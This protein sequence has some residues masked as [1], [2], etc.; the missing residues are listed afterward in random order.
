Y[1][2]SLLGTAHH[3]RDFAIYMRAAAVLEEYF[4]EHP[5]HP[6]VLHY[7]IHCYDDSVHAPLGVRA[8]RLYGAVAPDAGH[9]LHMTSHIFVALGQWD[10]VIAANARAMAVVNAQR[11]AAGRGELRCGHYPSWLVYGDLQQ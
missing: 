11:K 6:G 10:D 3:G 5:H 9:A 8:A 7:L 1:A 2:L 4:P